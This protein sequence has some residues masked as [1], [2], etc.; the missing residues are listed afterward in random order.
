MKMDKFEFNGTDKNICAFQKY[1]L[2]EEGS[3][4]SIVLSWKKSR[5]KIFV[6]TKKYDNEIH[7]K[8][9]RLEAKTLM[10][11][12]SKAFYSFSPSK[13]VVSEWRE[14]KNLDEW[15]RIANS[16]VGSKI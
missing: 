1:N 6:A 5:K 4:L 7:E 12:S 16:H 13:F 9:L 3:F 14:K 10:K 2:E 11:F 8:E 15:R